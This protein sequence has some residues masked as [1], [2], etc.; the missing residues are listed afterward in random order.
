MRARSV[1]VGDDVQAEVHAHRISRTC[2]TAHWRAHGRRDGSEA[3]QAQ[4]NLPIHNIDRHS[5]ETGD[6]SG[7]D[8]RRCRCLED[9]LAPPGRYL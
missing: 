6:V 1:A 8:P 9:D 7:F 3:E 4:P 2:R 5:E